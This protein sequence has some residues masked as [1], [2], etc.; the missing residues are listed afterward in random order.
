MGETKFKPGG[1]LGGQVFTLDEIF[2][3]YKNP[4]GK[5]AMVPRKAIDTVVI[6]P[7]KRGVSFLKLVGK[8]T[9]L[10]SIEMPQPWCEK[11][12]LWLMEQLGI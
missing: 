4:Y 7:K 9:E 3:K 11:T 12:Q 1:L 10:A 2:F 5:Y 8:G 6:E